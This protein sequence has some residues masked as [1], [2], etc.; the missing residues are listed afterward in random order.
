MIFTIN[1]LEDLTKYDKEM[2][3]FGKKELRSFIK[4]ELSRR[5]LLGITSTS[6]L[7]EETDILCGEVGYCATG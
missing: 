6:V 2:M 7:M 4:N 3:W 5:R 1:S